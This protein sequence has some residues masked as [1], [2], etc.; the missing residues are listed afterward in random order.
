MK[1]PP[2]NIFIFLYKAW[3]WSIRSEAY[4][5]FQ[6]IVI[7]FDDI[8]SIY[9]YSTQWDMTRQ[10]LVNILLILGELCK[11]WTQEFRDIFM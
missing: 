1:C 8:L 4:S 7:V 11:I 9:I 6:Y 5:V 2:L 3:W 10:N